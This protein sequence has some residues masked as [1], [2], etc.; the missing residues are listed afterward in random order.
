[1]R[2]T[3]RITTDT[4]AGWG[5]RVGWL[6]LIWLVSVGVLGA[7]TAALRLALTWAGPFS[8]GGTGK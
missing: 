7:V 8:D 1:M 3:S 6:I 5:Q 4:S 2:P